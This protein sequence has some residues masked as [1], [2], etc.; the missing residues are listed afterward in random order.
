MIVL[1]R[2]IIKLII[3]Y[4]RLEDDVEY[5]CVAENERGVVICKIKFNIICK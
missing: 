2:N 5:I 3:D 1:E 4:F